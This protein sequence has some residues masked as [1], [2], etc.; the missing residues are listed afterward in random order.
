MGVLY[1]YFAADSDGEAASVIDRVAGPSTRV[2][3]EGTPP[4][5]RG[6]FSRRPVDRSASGTQIRDTPS[7]E[8]VPAKG[9]DPIIQ[10]GTLEELLTGRPYDDITNDPRHGYLVADRDGGERLVVAL[11]DSLAG[12]LA[13]ATSE[14]LNDV[15][16]PW[17][18]TEEFWGQADPAALAEFLAKL[19][20]LATRA[21]QK[22]QH[23]YCW[24]CV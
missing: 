20:G 4:T 19:A 21:Q 11:T 7:Y 3:P 15:A 9:I 13:D 16:V 14:R 22:E 5:R 17:A 24:V 6:W 23:L 8:T 12:S 10:M 18:E 2:R 1:D